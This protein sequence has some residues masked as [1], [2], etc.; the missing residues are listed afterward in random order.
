[1]EFLPLE[2]EGRDYIHWAALAQEYARWNRRFMLALILEFFAFD[3]HEEHIIESIHNY[4]DPHD[5]I[6]RKGAIAA[7][8]GQKVVIPL[9]M[10]DGTLLGVG[11]GNPEYNYSAPHGAGR[12]HSR[13]EMMRRL[14]R[15]DHTLQE[16][17]RAMEGIFSTSVTPGTFDESPFAYKDP[18]MIE[19]YLHACVEI[20]TRLKPVY[21]LKAEG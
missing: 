20:T 10:A 17:Q 9:N 12:L 6:I 16:Y 19:T 1:M 4:I 15:G 3:L 21:N 2:G 11:K 13:R 7:H 14:K 18:A 8:A 5:H